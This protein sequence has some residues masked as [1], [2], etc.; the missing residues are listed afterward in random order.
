M[1]KTPP[2]GPAL[3]EGIDELL[4]PALRVTSKVTGSKNDPNLASIV[5]AMWRTIAANWVDGQCQWRGER[6]WR[7]KLCE[8]LADRNTSEEVKLNRTLARELAK[9]NPDAWANEVPT[10][11]GL[12]AKGASEPGGLDFA[13]FPREGQVVLIELKVTSNTPA[14]AAFQVVIY[15]LMLH[16]AQRV[17][18]RL[19]PHRRKIK[20]SEKWSKADV[21]DLRVLAPTTYYLP[22]LNL[23]SFETA[24]RNEVADFGKKRNLSMSFGFRCFD[25]KPS[26]EQTLRAALAREVPW[27]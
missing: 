2:A 18:Q 21:I 3:C 5:E 17:H 11:S 22:H 27:Q 25:E 16:L 4:A 14:S 7:S 1:S 19:L 10:G 26:N 9:T 6:N 12:A 8:T 24:L 23:R 20:I 15:G 13:H